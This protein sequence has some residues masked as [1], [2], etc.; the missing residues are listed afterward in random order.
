[1]DTTEKPRARGRPRAFDADQA[2]ATAQKLFHTH[3]Y[4]GVSVAEITEALGIKP[5]SF[6]AAFGSKHGLYLRVLE[7]YAGTGAV[8]LPELLR[9]DRPLAESLVAVLEEAARR[10]ADD[11]GTCGC[12]VLASVHSTDAEAREVASSA[13]AAAEATIRSFIAAR[14]PAEAERLTDFISTTM[15]GL[16]ANARNGHTLEQ[17]LSTARLAGLAIT[18]ILPAESP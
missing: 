8:P 10:Y 2:I 15:A 17:L 14:H 5:P 9:D 12:L 6:Y 11:C 16:S 13:Q 18:Q 1:M 7:R 4:D 3:G